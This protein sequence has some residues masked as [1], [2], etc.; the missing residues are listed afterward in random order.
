[1]SRFR[2][3]QSGTALFTMLALTAGAAT[4][5]VIQAP[6]QAQTSFSDV[7]SGYWAEGFIQELSRRNVISGFPD[8]SFRPNDPV[9]RA[10]FAAMV[11][12]AFSRSQIRQ[13][14]G[15]VDV[16]S[17]YWANAAIQDAYATGF[18]SGYPGNVFRPE[19]YIPRAQVLVSLANGLGYTPSNTS[20]SAL[21]VYRDAGSIPN[22]AAG[23]IAAATEKRIVVNYPN[24][25]TLNPNR[26][27][28][29]AEV[30][31][32]IYQALVSAGQTASIA[33][34]YIVGETVTSSNQIPSGTT[35]AVR[36]EAEKILLSR[37]EPNPVPLTLSLDRDVVHSGRVLI[38]ANS[39]VAGELR[40][41][42]DG[43]RF[44]AK[45]LILSNNT[46]IP[47]SA[48]SALVTNTQR[49][50]KGANVVEILAG[51]ALGA[52]A[53]AAITGL[54]GDRVVEPETVLGGGAV[55][56]V[57]GFLLGRDRVTLISINPNTDLAL[58]L[59]APLA[60]R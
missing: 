7:S 53:A 11:R 59:N 50:T 15:F 58:T 35:L 14:A 4:P 1:M 36:H 46:T 19:E 2:P 30:A 9:T 27:A 38:P 40:L 6:A 52:G 45:E 49:V 22:W 33:S 32:F 51:A 26:S 41:E 25:D 37:E 34:P 42:G 18:L 39:R 56:A 48:T 43:A 29:R 10:Q 8:G 57:A 17:N 20:G 55:G 12:K 23:S 31:A 24:V 28:T 54:T 16:P 60:M 47:I 13:S 3:M 5:I 44:H 21:Q